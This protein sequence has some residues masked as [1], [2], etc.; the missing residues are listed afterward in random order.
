MILPMGVAIGIGEEAHLAP[1]WTLA[2]MRG[3]GASIVLARRG[4]AVG[5]QKREAPPFRKFIGSKMVSEF[6]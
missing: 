5:H 2:M 3:G 4:I 1:I 6:K